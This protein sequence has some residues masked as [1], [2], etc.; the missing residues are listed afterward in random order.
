MQQLLHFLERPGRCAVRPR[1]GLQTLA[2][3]QPTMRIF[4][5]DYATDGNSPVTANHAAVIGLA[6]LAIGI[7]AAAFLRRRPWTI[8]QARPALNTKSRHAQR[9]FVITIVIS[10]FVAGWL[11]LASAFPDLASAIGGAIGLAASPPLIM[12]AIRA[13]RTKATIDDLLR[14]A[15]GDNRRMGLP[16][17]P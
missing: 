1:L 5:V 9:I 12:G 7:V 10:S 17:E 6:G 8:V 14:N 11:G 2:V 3:L 4:G 13:R 15:R 16:V